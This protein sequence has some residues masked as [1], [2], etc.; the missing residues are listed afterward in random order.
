[1]NAADVVAILQSTKISFRV[2]ERPV[3]FQFDFPFEVQRRENGERFKYVNA[4]ATVEQALN[5]AGQEF[6]N[7]FRDGDAID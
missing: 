2:V 7:F 4:F 1:M 6:A 5:C 3:N